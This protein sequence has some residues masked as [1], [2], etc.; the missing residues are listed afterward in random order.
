[1]GKSCWFARL[2]NQHLFRIQILLIFLRFELPPNFIFY[3]Y[4]SQT[5]QFYLV[6]P[7]LFISG[8]HK[9]WVGHVTR[10]CKGL[11]EKEAEREEKKKKRERER[12]DQ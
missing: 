12:P 8:T 5:W 4:R 6:F 10:S 11:S 9:V 2:A 1:M 7:S 3:C